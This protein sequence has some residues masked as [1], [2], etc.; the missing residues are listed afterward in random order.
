[1]LASSA[2]TTDRQ[3]ESLYPDFSSYVY[4]IIVHL[5]FLQPPFNNMM[6]NQHVAWYTDKRLKAGVKERV[7][8]SSMNINIPS[9][10]L[11]DWLVRATR[12]RDVFCYQF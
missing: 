10:P 7:W 6:A 9:C 1:M 4:P 2:L 11:G 8:S 3:W 5:Q 12:C